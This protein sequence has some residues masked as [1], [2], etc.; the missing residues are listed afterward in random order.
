[1]S[2]SYLYLRVLPYQVN[3]YKLVYWIGKVTAA[4]LGRLIIVGEVI[5]HETLFVALSMI[6][7]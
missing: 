6:L 7:C 1:M 2:K 4:M 5:L 3:L